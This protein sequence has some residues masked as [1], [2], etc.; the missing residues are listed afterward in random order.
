MQLN[1]SKYFGLMLVIK[2]TNT[3]HFVNSVEVSFKIGTFKRLN[4]KQLLALFSRYDDDFT[5]KDAFWCE[6]CLF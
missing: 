1:G 3:V 6:F 2:T 5:Q 4:R